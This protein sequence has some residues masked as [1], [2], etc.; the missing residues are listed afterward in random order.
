[1]S[2]NKPAATLAEIERASIVRHYL[3]QVESQVG[4]RFYGLENVTAKGVRTWSIA[5]R[6]PKRVIA[7]IKGVERAPG[8]YWNLTRF[9]NKRKAWRTI[10]LRTVN[11]ITYT[12]SRGRHC[13][14]TFI[15]VP[16]DTPRDA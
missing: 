13:E 14:R 3:E 15:D 4:S 16:H 8:P 11:R 1:M 7:E 12:D 2:K 10:D 9:C 6:A 5:P